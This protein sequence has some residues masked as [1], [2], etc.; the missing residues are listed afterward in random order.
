MNPRNA[1]YVQVTW[2]SAPRTGRLTARRRR[3]N[4]RYLVTEG[5]AGKNV[6]S[7]FQKPR[8]QPVETD[9]RRELAAPRDICGEAAIQERIR[10]ST[11]LE[12]IRPRA[13]PGDDGIALRGSTGALLSGG[14]SVGGRTM[15]FRV[16]KSVT[17]GKGIRLNL[18]RT[19]IGIS[20][21]VPGAR[22]SLHS[23]GRRTT[24]VGIPG[25][26]IS[27]RTDRRSSTRQAGP[28][29]RPGT[30]SARIPL[31]A[32]RRL[33][34]FSR[35]VRAYAAGDVASALNAF[36]EVGATGDA[37]SASL[38]EALCLVALERPGEAILP[39]EDV[40]ASSTP[41][42]DDLMRR[43]MVSGRLVV[44]ITDDLQADVPFDQVGAALLL[45]E[46]HQ[47][48][49]NVEE[50]VALL[51]TI[52]SHAPSREM[53]L[54]LADLYVASQ[55]WEDA[56]RVSDG[57]ARNEDDVSLQIVL[58]R[59]RALREAGMLPS[60]REALKEAM[61]FKKRDPRLLATARY[62]R[63]LLNEVSGKRA[64]ARKDLEGVF[65]FD[66]TFAD[67]GQRLGVA[68][69]ALPPPPPPEPAAP[70]RPS[71]EPE[72]PRR[73][74]RQ[75]RT[76]IGW[77][78]AHP[79]VA[80]I[81]AAASIVAIIAA[82]G[83][84][85]Q[86][87]V[88]RVATTPSTPQ[89]SPPSSPSPSPVIE[90]IPTVEVP[91]LVGLRQDRAERAAERRD[92]VVL[93]DT[94]YSRKPAG[95]VL[96]QDV[97]PGTE[98]EASSTVHVVIAKAYPVIPDVVGDALSSAR[99]QLD[100]AGYDVT[101]R[102]ESSTRP[103]GTVLSMTPAGGSEALPGRNVTIVVAEAPPPP[104]APTSNCSPYYTGACLDPNASDYDCAG[105]SGDGPKYVSGPVG[106]PGSD[107]FGLDS[108][109]DGV[110][111]ES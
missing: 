89:T 43:S 31:F 51:E 4:E 70:L 48:V 76:F 59:A 63:A 109:G 105:G 71:R 56:I 62:E 85:A 92:L 110:G 30:P 15:G 106:V 91:R 53:A 20:A 14:A 111:C 80:G 75:R 82:L 49:G 1:P 9:H 6:A 94:T 7:V 95:T 35:A 12:K 47:Q 10:T 101:V 37:T 5:A 41:L 86:D 57:F 79:G 69:P 33:K 34:T 55:R 17:L 103:P 102:R 38:F 108:D 93:V 2:V 22:Y 46:V 26:G 84:D 68:P 88:T 97:R 13:G 90:E 64:Q 107:P 45:A 54:S 72:P 11:E 8:L 104:S 32:S 52:G 28:P 98:L 83:S 36:R 66:P 18:S 99:R 61:R 24:T 40:V 81:G 67:V 16:Y 65:A 50:A 96:R 19:G 39:L 73:D 23:S 3:G 25:S 27:Y 60:A 74:R 78:R 29:A 58:L 77:L 42:P 87:P 21:G 100:R 44:Q